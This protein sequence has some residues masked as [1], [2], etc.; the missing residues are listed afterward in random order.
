M[1]FALDAFMFGRHFGIAVGISNGNQSVRKGDGT[2]R[3]C[4][5]CVLQEGT[6]VTKRM[7]EGKG[8]ELYVDS[9]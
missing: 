7:T 6:Y 3:S 4:V 5:D 8:E 9:R 1:V 2:G